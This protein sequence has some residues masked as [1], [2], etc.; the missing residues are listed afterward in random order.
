[1]IS[2]VPAEPVDPIMPEELGTS[3]GF[4]G[5]ASG[6]AQYYD[7]AG[8]DECLADTECKPKLLN[9]YL[10]DDFDG[11]KC[12]LY[13]QE[14]NYNTWG[15]CLNACLAQTTSEEETEVEETEEVVP[16]ELFCEGDQVLSED[17][18]FK[19]NG[20]TFEYKNLN[21]NEP[22]TA[23]FKHFESGETLERSVTPEGKFN[24]KSK[25]YTYDFGTVGDLVDDADITCLDVDAGSE[26]VAFNLTCGESQVIMKGHIFTV[27]DG[28]KYEYLGSDDLDADDPKAKFKVLKNGEVIERSVNLQTGDFT[29]KHKGTTYHFEGTDKVDDFNIVCED[30]TE[31]A[32]GSSGGSGG[33]GTS[34]NYPYCTLYANEA[35]PDYDGN[36]FCATKGADY[37]ASGFVIIENMVGPDSLIP[38]DCSNSISQEAVNQKGDEHETYENFEVDDVI[39]AYYCCTQP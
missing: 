35:I 18:I 36:E 22:A 14:K 9:C 23:K 16:I 25:G 1:M 30:V 12:Y 2:C 37:C 32:S 10:N 8:V 5:Q 33:S 7:K 3:S 20:D 34:S 15:N 19:M 17:D 6:V 26:N 28:T 29:I 38:I 39:S 24:I 31:E 21:D 11:K 13:Y 27:F 4:L